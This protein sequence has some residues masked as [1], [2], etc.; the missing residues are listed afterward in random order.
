MLDMSA[1]AAL[2]AVDRD[3]HGDANSLFVPW[4]AACRPLDA[5]LRPGLSAG[6]GGNARRF[7]RR[8]NPT[9][10]RLDRRP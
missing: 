7:A 6:L 8:G 2:V 9:G 1:V 4:C 5:C 3:R 10:Y